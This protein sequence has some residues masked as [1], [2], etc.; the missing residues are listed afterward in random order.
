M[1]PNESSK[2]DWTSLEDGNPEVVAQREFEKE[3]VL[4]SHPAV[5]EEEPQDAFP[6]KWKNDFE[7]LAYLGYLTTT[8]RI[9]FHTFVLKTL[10]PIEKIEVADVCR[11]HEDSLAYA[12]S[13]KAAIV[14]AALLTVDGQPLIV[15]ERQRNV[16]RQ[17]YEYVVN[18]WYEPIIDLLYNS[19]NALELRSLEVLRAMGILGEGGSIVNNEKSK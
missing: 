8:V 14:A 15:G 13:F 18:T 1:D 4:E 11:S 9:P 2:E 12:K 6:E 19:V 10:L 16:V 17:K 5:E 7:G 3:S